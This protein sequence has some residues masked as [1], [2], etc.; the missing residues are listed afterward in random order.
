MVR[1]L[2]Q[3]PDAGIFVATD[4]ESSLEFMKAQ[5]PGHVVAYDS[6]RHRSG[7][8]AGRGPTGGLIPAYIARSPETA[9]QNGEQAIIEYLL[10]RRCRCLVHN[11]SNL[12]RTVL[13][14]EPAM[15][16]I[17]TNLQRNRFLARVRAFRPVK[18]LWMARD[19]RKR[20][21]YPRGAGAIRK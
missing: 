17:N 5:F 4:A 2:A 14:A 15:L 13:L 18:F 21:L 9:A 20:L 1:L 19:I 8:A 11:G 6:I 16:H 7:K 3:A 12:A 10:L